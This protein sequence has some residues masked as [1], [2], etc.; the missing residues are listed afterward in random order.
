MRTKMLLA[1]VSICAFAQPVVAQS[2]A[3]AAKLAP[4][5]IPAADIVVT[6]SR[7]IANGNSS[8]TPLT[9]VQAQEILT[10]TPSTMSDAINQLPVFSAPR[11]QVSNP[12][13]GAGAGGGGNGVANQLNLRNLL[14][15]RTLVLFDGHRVAP[16]TST[17]IVD[18]DT[19]PQF[20]LKR[21]DVVTGGVSAIYGSDAISGVVNFVTDKDFNGFKSNI[22]YGQTGRGEA[23]AFNAAVAWGKRL[24]DSVH[25]EASYEYRDDS[26]ILNRSARPEVWL[27]T[28]QGLGTAAS[29]YYLTDQARRVDLTFGGIVRSGVLSGSNFYTQGVASP[30]NFGTTAGAASVRLG[31]DGAYFD[32]SLKAPLRSH[33]AFAR[34]DFDPSSNLHIYLQGALNM[35]RNDI[36]AN[37]MTLSNVTL[38]ATNA[39]LPSTYAAQM[40]TAGQSSFTF[41]KWVKNAPRLHSQI[42]E[43]QIFANLGAN[44]TLGD[45]FKWELGY[46]HS[47]SVLN[48]TEFN[49]VNNLRLAAALDAVNVGGS[50]QCANVATFAGCV[51]LNPFGPGSESQEAINYV[52]GTTHFNAY[53]KQDDVS[54]SLSGALFALPAGDVKAAI[55][56][57]WRRQTYRATSDTP[58]NYVTDCLGLT[59]N[60]N[61]R[62]QYQE[63]FQTFVPRS[64]VAQ[65]VSEAALE[66]N[67]PL[68]KDVALARDLS[69]N[70]AG[71]WTRYD[72]SGTQYT[73]KLGLDWHVADD[74]RLR[75]TRS[76][77]IRAPTLDDL[78]AATSCFAASTT[79]L[80]TSQASSA[81][82]C[83]VANPNLNAEVGNTL[84]AGLIWKPAGIPGFSMSLDYYNIEIS[85]AINTVV[86]TNQSIQ[87]ACYNSGGTSVYCALQ[88]RTLGNYTSKAVG[89]SVTQWRRTV[90][91]IARITTSGFDFEANY[92][93]RLFNRP[94]A[95]RTM[96]TY[97]PHIR[98]FQPGLAVFDM[99]GIAYGQNGLQAS[100]KWR[101]TA[102]LNY[103]PVDGLNVT[104]ME[105]WRSA[106]GLAAD[107]TQ[108]VTG[109]RVPAYAT[110]NLNVTY[111][112]PFGDRK[113]EVF[114]NVQNLFDN[115]GPPA[116]FSGSQTNVGLFGGFAI[117]DDPIGRFITVGAKYRF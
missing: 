110:T 105:R 94:F 26:G 43:T 5:Q 28:V 55:S 63:W 64:K 71:R 58:N 12:N 93:R 73:W 75:A 82:D 68:L 10:S 49:N 96:V 21:V 14:P 112:L 116:N 87:T 91:N 60:C 18:S 70:A 13:T 100:P 42:D 113:A 84:T 77:D 101:V 66:L 3:G 48:N 40:A 76:R 22:Q 20:L 30:F 24:S 114:L 74:W 6:G 41:G 33:Q 83:T 50:I 115:I 81:L 36:W 85:N 2:A 34:V 45:R 67:V 8:P 44:G 78:F 4:E 111:K 53:T 46:V 108:Y 37:W 69:V 19:I 99:G 104:V 9:V 102:F 56:G 72:T 106:M 11:T 23:P 80:L 15:Q 65:V 88:D 59:R 109:P 62:G 17:G 47:E 39:F 51:P 86:G 52:M 79:D 92:A 38:S 25:F 90:F 95:L 98:Y 89:N 54:A 61:T 35:K 1:G 103:S 117:G 16:T 27:Q 7:I 107:P 31:G 97:Q 29:P 32:G 57:E